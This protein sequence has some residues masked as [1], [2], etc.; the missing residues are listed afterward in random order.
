MLLINVY[1]Y[2]F[3]YFL[4]DSALV[5]GNSAKHQPQKVGLNHVLNDEDV[6]QLVKQ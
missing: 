2:L 6:V 4:N 5:W 1:I 3:I